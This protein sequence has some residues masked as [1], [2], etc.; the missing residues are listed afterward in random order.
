VRCLAPEVPPCTQ[1]VRDS[2]KAAGESGRCRL[3]K[4]RLIGA[5]AR[6]DSPRGPG[7]FR[8]LVA[9]VLIAR[10]ASTSD[11]NLSAGETVAIFG[12]LSQGVSV[13]LLRLA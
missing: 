7:L 6:L 4:C 9:P 8:A 11:R 1:A 12:R 5:T 2:G 13:R 10:D 3:I